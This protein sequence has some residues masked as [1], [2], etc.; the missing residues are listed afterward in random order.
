MFIKPA[1]LEMLTLELLRDLAR[2]YQGL[3][4]LLFDLQKHIS[5]NDNPRSFR[6][7]IINFAVAANPFNILS[8]LVWAQLLAQWQPSPWWHHQ[9][10]TFSVLLAICAGIHWSPVNS[11]HKG[12]WRGAL[13][14]SLICAS[15][16]DWVNNHETGDLRRHCAH[17]DV[18]VMPWF[19]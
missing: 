6:I 7:M 17:C 12:Q 2:C 1:S 14:F 16:N 5:I 18:I 11:P 4:V 8:P 19:V 13:M 15:I 3:R 10:E 9:M